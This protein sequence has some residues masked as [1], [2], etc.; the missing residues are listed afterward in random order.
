MSFDE[1]SLILIFD[2]IKHPYFAR[3]LL[4]KEK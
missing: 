3:I 2:N 4:E 1:N